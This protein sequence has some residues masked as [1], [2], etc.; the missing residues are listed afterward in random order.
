LKTKK[1]S[2][3]VKQSSP[4]Q[5]TLVLHMIAQPNVAIQDTT[6]AQLLLSKQLSIYH[7]LVDECLQ[8]I[9]RD[10]M[11]NVQ[12]YPQGTKD[13]H[14][15]LIRQSILAD[16]NEFRTNDNHTHTVYSI[17]LLSKSDVLPILPWPIVQSI[18]VAAVKPNTKAW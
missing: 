11:T 14:T 10:L 3:T 2:R 7:I 9:Y 16:M 4:L 17:S 12:Q 18:P 5:N 6:A 1:I 13:V 15:H 8:D